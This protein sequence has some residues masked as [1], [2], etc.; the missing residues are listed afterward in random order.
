MTDQT[1]HLYL[2]RHGATDNN[3]ARPPHL[4]GC[5]LDPPLAAAGWRQSEQSAAFLAARPVAAVYSSPLLRARQTAETI[6]RPHNL[7]LQTVEA[8]I[9][10]NV[11]QWEGRSWDEIQKTEPEE[12]RR[13][14][15]NPHEYG[16]RGGESL[17]QVEERVA[18]A[19][20][21]LLAAHS[22]QHI[23][24]V[25]H[26]VVNR[27][28]LGQLLDVPP[29][30]RRGVP[31]ENC[32]LNVIRCEAGQARLLTLNSVWHLQRVED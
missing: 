16:Y 26:N 11:G 22:G 6:A 29:A 4:Q 5:R 23:V 3:L 15:A 9:E 25:A 2:L 18:P 8:L 28:Y 30:K 14:T 19:F 32:G 27:V 12:Y 10:C 31:Q 17:R 1:C 24:V 7:E 20:A 13:F 21:R